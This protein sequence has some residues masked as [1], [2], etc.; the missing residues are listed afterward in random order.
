[1]NIKP[2]LV[3]PSQVLGGNVVVSPQE[4]VGPNVKFYGF[5]VDWVLAKGCALRYGQK[6]GLSFTIKDGS[7]FLH[8]TPETQGLYFLATNDWLISPETA[9]APTGRGKLPLA[10]ILVFYEP[11]GVEVADFGSIWDRAQTFQ[12]EVERT[13]AGG[14]KAAIMLNNFTPIQ[15][16]LG[17][18]AA[19][20]F[21]GGPF[22]SRLVRLN[23]ILAESSASGRV[24]ALWAGANIF[25]GPPYGA[26]VA[27]NI[28]SEVALPAGFTNLAGGARVTMG[29]D[30]GFAVNWLAHPDVTAANDT[31]LSD[32]DWPI[33]EGW[34][35]A[36]CDDTPATTL[37]AS[38]N[39]SVAKLD[40]ETP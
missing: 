34:G 27:R 33:L 37:Y 14:N 5:I 7:R 22:G 28:L 39:Y 36:I 9:D 26:G 15:Q 23:S 2:F 11:A 40:P 6:T 30:P 4:I 25:G 12:T 17:G 35:L 8:Q 32:L 13:S 24:R 1:M 10:R 18:A 3:Q 29:D 38:L 31:G 16:G 19:A 21:P 20:L